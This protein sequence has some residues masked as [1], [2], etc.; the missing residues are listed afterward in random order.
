MTKT[1]VGSYT[2]STL[3]HKNHLC[4]KRS[5]RLISHNALRAKANTVQHIITSGPHAGKRAYVAV[6]A[7]HFPFMKL[8]LELRQSI[9]KMV[10]GN[11]TAITITA[12]KLEC[13]RTHYKL[14][15]ASTRRLSYRVSSVSS[16]QNALLESDTCS[17]LLTTRAISAEA[18]EFL[19]RGRHFTFPGIAIMVDWLSDI[20][21]C[22]KYVTHITCEKSGHRL[23][24]ACYVQLVHAVRLQY[25]K[26][27]LPLTFNGTLREHMDKHYR[28][29]QIY[30]LARGADEAES[31]RRLD[32]IHFDIGPDQRGV[33]DN[34]GLVLRQ[35]TPDMERSCKAFIR[36]KLQKHYKKS[37]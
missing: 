35:M 24:R 21:E 30:L 22:R 4:S 33:R 19:Y 32:C 37:Q 18:I 5:G 2:A 13:A 1:Q 14:V 26:I 7:N 11:K 20:K 27:N 8:P 28:D 29:L 12:K 10:L 15:K 6:K 23:T 16:L 9:Y 36:A 25:F 31:L 17:L 34:N 3:N